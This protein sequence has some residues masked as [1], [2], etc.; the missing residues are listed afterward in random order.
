MKY[1]GSLTGLAEQQTGRYYI[2][3]SVVHDQVICYAG[4]AGN[5]SIGDPASVND[6]TEAVGVLLSQN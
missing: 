3:G 4:L 2:G 5:G 6:Y 1:A